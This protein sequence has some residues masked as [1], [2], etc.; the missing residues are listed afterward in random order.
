MHL[1][2]VRTGHF[3]SCLPGRP[4]TLHVSLDAGWCLLIG[5]RTKEE[6]RR[7]HWVTPSSQATDGLNHARRVWW[8]YT[9]EI[10]PRRLEA[11]KSGNVRRNEGPLGTTNV[12]SRA[13]AACR[14]SAHKQYARDPCRAQALPG[15]SPAQPP[16][17]GSRDPAPFPFGVF[18]FGEWHEN[19]SVYS[20]ESVTSE[21]L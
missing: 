16:T 18:V 9:A 21:M 17:R 3:H 11:A 20:C 6:K 12:R 5:F 8:K 1:G 14:S 19:W 13:E 10:F 15:R 4:E 2:T 7:S